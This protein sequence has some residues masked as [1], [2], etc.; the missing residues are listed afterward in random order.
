MNYK[1]KHIITFLIFFLFVSCQGRPQWQC[2]SSGA[3]KS[4]YYDKRCDKFF[5]EASAKK[6]ETGVCDIK[7]DIAEE[8]KEGLINAHFL[9]D[10]Y[11]YYLTPEK[12]K[13][14]WS[15]P[16]KQCRALPYDPDSIVQTSGSSFLK[17][18]KAVVI[19]GKPVCP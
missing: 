16:Y 14:L 9:I 17:G 6:K 15:K 5:A 12:C 8:E 10:Y 11:E 7:P 3:L 4:T 1:M 19:D 2:G 18:N 13:E